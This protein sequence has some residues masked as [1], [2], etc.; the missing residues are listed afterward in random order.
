MYNPIKDLFPNS[1][2]QVNFNSINWSHLG[3][4]QKYMILFTGR[5]GSTFLTKL[6]SS[7]A[8]CGNPDEFFSE[9]YINYTK[10][11]VPGQEFR[12]YF[13]YTANKNKKNG[14]FGFEI[15][16]QRFF[17]LNQLINLDQ[18]LRPESGVPI[19]W[20]TRQDLIAQAYSFAMAKKTGLWHIHANG[21]KSE[22]EVINNAARIDER[23][24]WEE[25]LLVLRWEQRIEST[26][27]EMGCYPLR[28]T[29]EQLVSDKSVTLARVMAH[30]GISVDDIASSMSKI[31]ENEQLTV[32]L[33]Y[34]DKVGFLTQ[35]YTKH[36]HLINK[37]YSDRKNIDELF[38]NDYLQLITE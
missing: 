24:I 15:D 36:S 34:E 22:T 35:F 6:L 1:R 27:A 17:W 14:Y 31:S 28:I 13:E 3:V 25:L 11:E 33:E 18:I 37:I 38:I 10:R 29:Y 12:D 32:K 23:M 7:T 9:G 30:I 8:M 26:F 19:V 4:S 2:E 21:K 16:A 5:S 20:L